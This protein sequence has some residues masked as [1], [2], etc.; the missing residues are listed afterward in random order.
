MNC[1]VIIVI[2]VKKARKCQ[3]TKNTKVTS[4]KF[5]YLE[6][7]SLLLSTTDHK[8]PHN[9]WAPIYLYLDPEKLRPRL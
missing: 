1:S 4:S 8:K 5:V 7:V 6:E 3:P 9:D 2:T